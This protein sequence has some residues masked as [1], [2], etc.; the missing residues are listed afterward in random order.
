MEA[1][2][3][4]KIVRVEIV[5]DFDKSYYAN[6]YDE[7]GGSHNLSHEYTD[8]RTLKTLCKKEYGV[9][10]PNLSQIEFETHGRKSYAYT[11]TETPQISTETT[12]TVNVSTEGEKE[13][14]RANKEQNYCDTRIAEDEY[15][16]KYKVTRHWL[17]GRIESIDVVDLNCTPEPPQSPE[18]PQTVECAGESRKLAQ[19][20]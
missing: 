12:R 11:S 3:K 5:R 10:L 19:T 17:N 15:H 7:N 16:H 6:L 4:P 13:A 2:N 9:N 8:F 14:E 20:A 1:T 18:T